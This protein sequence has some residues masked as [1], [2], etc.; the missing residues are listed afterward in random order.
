MLGYSFSSIV[1]LTFFYDTEIIRWRDNPCPV[2]DFTLSS[3]SVLSHKI[4][5]TIN[6][7]EFLFKVLYVTN[8]R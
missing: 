7:C 1:L 2:S 6:I 8:T 4:I 3:Y 5:L